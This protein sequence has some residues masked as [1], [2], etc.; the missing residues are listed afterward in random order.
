MSHGPF[1]LD[2]APMM[3]RYFLLHV[4]HLRRDS[5]VN[6]AETSRQNQLESIL[7][8]L[9]N[10]WLPKE[11]CSNVWYSNEYGPLCGL[12]GMRSYKD[13]ASPGLIWYPCSLIRS[14]HDYLTNVNQ[15]QSVVK[16]HS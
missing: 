3:K 13:R 9:Y 7:V 11:W 14:Y 10:V 16:R 4:V 15:S 6:Y 1:S 2:K 5:F 12:N 8:L